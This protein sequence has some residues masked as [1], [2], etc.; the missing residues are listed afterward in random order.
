[1]NFLTFTGTQMRKKA[2]RKRPYFTIESA[3]TAILHDASEKMHH[4]ILFNR[5]LIAKFSLI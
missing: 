1:M 4:G 5:R 2:T 3:T